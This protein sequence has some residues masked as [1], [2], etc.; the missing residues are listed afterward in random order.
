M[1]TNHPLFSIVTCIKNQENHI[2]KNLE[3]LAEQTFRYFEHI[4]IDGKSTDNS[5]AVI[6]KY[7]KKYPNQARI[8]SYPPKGISAAMNSGIRHARGKYLLHLHADDSLHDPQVLADSAS[9]LLSHPELD[10]TYGQIRVI[11]VDG[12]QVGIFPG[13][14]LFKRSDSVLLK[15]YNFIPHQAVF[16]KKTVFNRYSGF[17]KSLSSQMDYDLWLRITGRTKW[18][19]Y[20]RLV[21][22][23]TIRSDAQS[24]SLIKRQEN[25]ANLFKVLKRHLTPSQ[26]FFSKRLDWVIQKY[27]RTLR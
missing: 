18:V 2:A 13:R 3:S 10:W 27:N 6:K 9:F 17:D 8:Y 1:I 15:Y 4:I 20:N 5:L 26:Y 19:F 24:S 7:Q 22:N 16:I 23:F 11:E 14:Y 25:Q 12:R 21:S